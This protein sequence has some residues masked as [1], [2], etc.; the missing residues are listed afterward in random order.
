M[1]PHGSILIVMRLARASSAPGELPRASQARRHV[2]TGTGR[3]SPAASR[4]PQSPHPGRGVHKRHLLQLRQACLRP[5]P[6]PARPARAQHVAR[7]L[8]WRRLSWN[9]A[10]AE[11]S[12]EGGQGSPGEGRAGPG[13]AGPSRKAEKASVAPEIAAPEVKRVLVE[14]RHVIG[15]SRVASAGKR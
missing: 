7:T 4:H 13:R 10:G 8:D 12:S 14:D 2:P 9:G 1:L 6:E 15:G 5:G 3:P 11:W